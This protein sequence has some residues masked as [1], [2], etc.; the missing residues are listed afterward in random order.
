MSFPRVWFITGATSGFGRVLTEIVL[1]N[2]EIVVATG[3]RVAALDDL[4]SQFPSDRL[5][6]VKLDVSQ[7]KEVV[8]AFAQARGAFGRVD[9][10]VN[11]AGWGAFGEVEA[12]QDDVVR[13]QFETNFWGAANVSREAVKVFREVNKPVGG[14]LFQI[15]SITGLTGGPAFGYYSASK[16]ALEGLTESLAADVDPAWN[17]KVTLIEPGAFRTSGP[18]NT[19]W[20]PA[21]P[22]YSNPALPSSQFRANKDN[23]PIKGDPRKAMQVVYDVAGFAD[24][25]LHL[26]L[27]KDCIAHA[28][29]RFE[30]FL[31]ETKKYEYLSENLDVDE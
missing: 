28:R 30:A 14:R 10:V 9:V 17:I 11:N 20:P 15:S 29:K 16:F 13:A 26:P 7:P 8:D 31:E 25:P 21:H 1:Q 3:R 2:G 27:G 6:I 18:V 22:A 19:V 23:L 12:A 24:P 4:K 5:L